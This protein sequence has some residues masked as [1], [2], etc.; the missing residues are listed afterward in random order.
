VLA[1]IDRVLNCV[2]NYIADM[3]FLK[4][5]LYIFSW[6]QKLVMTAVDTLQKGH[7]II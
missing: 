2:V 3:G 7:V 6:L 5:G 4:S 1:E